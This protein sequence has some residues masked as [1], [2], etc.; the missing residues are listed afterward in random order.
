LALFDISLLRLA[1]FAWCNLQENSLF[2]SY[3]GL[4]LIQSA[5]HV[6]RL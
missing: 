1:I 2:S 6:S 4:Q 5:A 3:W